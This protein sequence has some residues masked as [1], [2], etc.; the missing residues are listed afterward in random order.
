MEKGDGRGTGNFLELDAGIGKGNHPGRGKWSTYG[1]KDEEV[2]TKVMGKLGLSF[3]YKSNRICVSLS[4]F[5]EGSRLVLNRY[6]S[7]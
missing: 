2:I 3:L 6:C 7:F 5:T 1:T 4:V